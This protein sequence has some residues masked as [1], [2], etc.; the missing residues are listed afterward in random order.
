MMLAKGRAFPLYSGKFD[1]SGHW[2]EVDIPVETRWN[3]VEGRG[4]SALLILFEKRPSLDLGDSQGPRCRLLLRQLHPFPRAPWGP[5]RVRHRHAAPWPLR[6]EWSVRGQKNNGSQCV[7]AMDADML[8]GPALWNGIIYGGGSRDG[9]GQHHCISR[10]MRPDTGQRG[11]SSLSLTFRYL[12]GLWVYRSSRFVLSPARIFWKNY[13]E[14]RIRYQH[15]ERPLQR[16]RL[17]G[18]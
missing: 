4:L 15:H 17:A 14:Q 11:F 8:I 10:A 7:G 3:Q 16:W 13:K 12:A 9:R 6:T 2:G 1:R 5:F 18:A